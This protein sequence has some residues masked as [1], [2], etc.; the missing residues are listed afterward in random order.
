MS[1][2]L[3]KKIEKVIKPEDVMQLELQSF[4]RN[5]LKMKIDDQKIRKKC[6]YN[7]LEDKKIQLLLK[8]GKLEDAKVYVNEL[9]TC[10]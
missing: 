9:I 10:I 5:I 1:K 3:R 6:L 2:E 8:E 7:I 4:A